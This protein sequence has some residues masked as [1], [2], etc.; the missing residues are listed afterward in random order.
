MPDPL[1]QAWDYIV[2]NA[3][4]F[5][6][7][8]LAFGALVLV[9]IAIAYAAASWRYSGII[10]SKQSALDGK[11]SDI[12]GQ[13]LRI[14]ALVAEVANLKQKLAKKEPESLASA[15]RDPDGIY[16]FGRQVGRGSGASIDLAS[17][18]IGFSA[19]L[20]TADLNIN[21]PLEF[22]Q[23]QMRCHS[24]LSSSQSSMGVVTSQ[25]FGRPECQILGLHP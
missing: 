24:D 5:W 12:D 15:G 1:A 19:I 18:A 13:R 16:Q 21:M 3:R 22:R 6:E 20:G 8:K 2:G 7:A 17:G 14:D 9:S 4:V 25:A 23:Y 10:D 11:Q